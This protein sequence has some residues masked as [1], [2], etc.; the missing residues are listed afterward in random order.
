MWSGH[1]GVVNIAEP[2][3]GILW[4]GMF[5]VTGIKFS[6]KKWHLELIIVNLQPCCISVHK[7]HH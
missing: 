2:V 6:M 4:A 7:T 5:S 3:E 1:K